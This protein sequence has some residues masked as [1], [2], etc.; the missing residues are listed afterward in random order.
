MSKRAEEN[1]SRLYAIVGSETLGSYL[2]IQPCSEN[3]PQLSKCSIQWYRVSP[4]GSWNEAI[5]G[6]HAINVSNFNSFKQC[7]GW[8]ILFDGVK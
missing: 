3:A 2:Q 1:K 5:S 4:E 6:I 7:S 8:N